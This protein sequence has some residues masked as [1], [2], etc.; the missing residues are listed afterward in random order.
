MKL[1]I[2]TVLALC[3]MLA[4]VTLAACSPQTRS[5]SA[6]ADPA[7]ADNAV[8]VTWSP[9]S[10]CDT[11]HATQQSSYENSACLVSSHAN[12]TCAVCHDD[13]SALATA[14]EGKTA[15]DK[16][17]KKL[18]KTEI[19]DETCLSCHSGSRE[20]LAAEHPDIVVTD[21]NGTSVNPHD[22][23]PSE[24]HDIACSTCHSMHD[25]TPSAEQAHDTCKSCHHADVFECKT[26]HD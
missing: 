21:T 5:E 12:V 3:G 7:T 15:S 18:K 23:T 6:N 10:K 4:V 13:A 14:H 26:C 20:Q 8:S 1:R 24:S 16:M 25:D 11:C 19:N 2:A 9:D 22:L 17:P